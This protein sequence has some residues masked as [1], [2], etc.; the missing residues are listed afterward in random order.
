MRRSTITPL[1]KKGDK[2]KLENWRPVSLLNGDYKIIAKAMAMRLQNVVS[3]CINE[4]QTGFIEGRYIGTNIMQIQNAIQQLE[5]TNTNG[6][7]AFLDWR[8]AYDRVEW[9]FLYRALTHFRLGPSFQRWI[10]VLYTNIE[11]NTIYNGTRSPYF[12][13]TRGLRQ[14]CPLSPVLYTLVVEIFAENIRQNRDIQGLHL[15]N[16]ELKTQ[17]FADDSAAILTSEHSFEHFLK[18]I[19]LY[20]KAS[21]ARLNREKSA[22]IWVGPWKARRDNPL[23]IPKTDMVKYLGIWTGRKEKWKECLRQTWDPVMQKITK[24]IHAWQARR[25]TIYGKTLIT[26][27]LLAARLW[28]RVQV[29]PFPAGHRRSIE[30]NIWKFMWSGESEW[31]GRKV[32]TNPTT[33]GGVEAMDIGKEIVAQR[34]KW[35]HRLT[36]QETQK[37]ATLAKQ[38]G[39]TISRNADPE[40]AHDSEEEWTNV[41]PGVVKAWHVMD[42]LLKEAEKTEPVEKRTANH[43]K[44]PLNHN[45]MSI[46]RFYTLQVLAHVVAPNCRRKWMETT[47]STTSCDWTTSWRNLQQISHNVGNRVRE[48]VW[49][50][51]HRALATRNRT[52]HFRGGDGKERC[53]LCDKEVETPEHLFLSCGVVKAAANLFTELLSRVR[54]HQATAWGWEYLLLNTQNGK[55]S[56]CLVAM[57][58]T[59]IWRRRNFHAT[60]ETNSTEA[61]RAFGVWWQFRRDVRQHIQTLL[62]ANHN[63]TQIHNFWNGNNVITRMDG[64]E[65]AILL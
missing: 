64:D 52:R 56:N 2:E 30:A 32:M 45:K 38:Q 15:Q 63:P 53:A 27:A 54:K 7:I 17:L 60:N 28:Y 47:P 62:H 39:L 49:R 57:F 42:R 8:K 18:I 41:W 23:D 46:K 24:T 44:L 4:D 33:Q 6:V 34:A 22:A 25:L 21:G 20:S 5:Q 59:G 3:S 50:I 14:G 9:A 26:K 11:T 36:V 13:V 35:A 43:W 48:T 40:T 58:L 61:E 37:W 12:P 55:L 19:Y 1:Y 31:V 65:M 10:Q 16:T 51:L 29:M